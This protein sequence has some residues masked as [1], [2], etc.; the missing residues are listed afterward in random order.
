MLPFVVLGFG[1][2]LYTLWALAA[3]P[4]QV[5]AQRH[6]LVYVNQATNYTTIALLYAIATCGSPT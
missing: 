1:L 6:S 5:S 2:T 3:F 4:T